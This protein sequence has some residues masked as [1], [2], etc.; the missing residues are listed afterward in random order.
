MTGEQLLYLSSSVGL[1][2]G[3]NI[4]SKKIATDSS[5]RAQFFFSQ[6]MLFGAATV[7]LLLLGLKNL[8]SLSSTT[9][10]LGILYGVFL[11]LAQWAYT[12]ALGL[13][14]TSVCV[15]VYAM[16]FIVPTVSGHF[17]WDEEF[18]LLNGIGVA[19][20]AVVI[21]LSAKKDDKS[22][23]T[24]KAFIP[25]IITAMLS[26]GMLGI[27]QK[28]HQSKPVSYEKS[29]FVIIGLGFAFLASMIAFLCCKNK[30]LPRINQA[31]FPV[32]AGCCFGGA[33][34][35][36]TTLAGAM[37]SAVFFPLQNISTVFISALLGLIVFREKLT[38]KTVIILALGAVVIMLFSL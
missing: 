15:V 34:L 9:L 2:V 4:I 12:F 10:W 38:L 36:N 25:F 33:N 31:V 17:F 6:M 27:L 35:C 37:K 7:L 18:T 28:V 21:L 30:Q 24:S 29:Q 19:L 1:T 23:K 5:N 11:I 8:T 16:G 32:L 22:K 3:R 13:G 14:T 20:A 26:S